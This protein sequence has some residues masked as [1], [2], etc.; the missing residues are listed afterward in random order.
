MKACTV[1]IQMWE[2]HVIKNITFVP[3]ETSKE[4][5]GTPV[6]LKWWLW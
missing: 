4:I 5:L 2:I 1:V 6:M 3:M